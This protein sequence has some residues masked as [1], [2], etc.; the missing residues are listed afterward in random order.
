MG[1]AELAR[2]AATSKETIHFYVRE[3]LLRKPKKCSQSDGVYD[4]GHLEQ[5]KLIK[6]L[7]TESYLPLH[8]I[9]RV[10][11]EGHLGVSVHQLDLA[12]DLLGYSGKEVGS[13]SRKEVAQRTQLPEERISRYEE[14]GILRPVRVGRRS[15]F[16]FEDLRVARIIRRAELESGP[17]GQD[18][19]LERFRIVEKHVSELVQAELSHFFDRVLSAGK[20]G[21]ALEMLQGGR[22]TVGSYLA[23]SRTRRLREE[24]EAMLPAIESTIADLATPVFVQL[25][26]EIRAQLGEL[27]DRK[28]LEQEW[29]SDPDNLTVARRFL[30]HLVAMGDALAASE[31]YERAL[32]GIRSD[33]KVRVLYAE[34]LLLGDRHDEALRLIRRLRDEQEKSSSDLEVLW[35]AALIIHVRD[36][37]SRIESSAELIG[38]L[39]RAFAAFDHVRSEQTDDEVARARILLWSGRIFLMLPEFLGANQQ[40]IKDLVS[41]LREI[42]SFRA[43][44]RSLKATK[45]TA[46]YSTDVS[47]ACIPTAGVLERIELNALTFLSQGAETSEERTKYAAR[48]DALKTRA[49]VTS[50]LRNRVLR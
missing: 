7:R 49:T 50:S 14:A 47:K 5:L 6:R 48:V 26:P 12:A 8:A 40:G 37:F 1:I 30:E 11:Q 16:G 39:A 38:Y 2:R 35:G 9:K 22:G 41:C 44:L 25:E 27:E 28:A 46:P 15:R 4:E 45:S 21:Q 32:D 17:E 31:W 24:V 42:D 34:A 36:H 19:V 13:L 43:R 23:V 3:G 10:L 29:R 20:P 33:F 18:L